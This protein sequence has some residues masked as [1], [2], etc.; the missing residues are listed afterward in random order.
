[1]WRSAGL[2]VLVPGYLFG[3]GSQE[4]QL[5]ACGFCALAEVGGSHRVILEAMAAGK[6]GVLVNEHRPN[7][8]RV[9]DA[10]LCA[11]VYEES[12]PGPLPDSLLDREPMVLA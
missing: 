10:A 11:A 4:L 1:V 9:G 2:R 12:G 5:D 7:A 6:D 8:E 3:R